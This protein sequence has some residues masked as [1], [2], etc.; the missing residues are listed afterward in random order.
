MGAH[1]R[2]TNA[3]CQQLIIKDHLYKYCYHFPIKHIEI[4]FIL[5]VYQILVLNRR[6]LIQINELR[7]IYSSKNKVNNQNKQSTRPE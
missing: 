3:H 5:K 2:N 6:N 7:F 4:C 1:V